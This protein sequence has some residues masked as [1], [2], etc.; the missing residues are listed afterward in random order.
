[1]STFIMYRKPISA[2]TPSLVYGYG[3]YAI[4]NICN[5]GQPLTTPDHSI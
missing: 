3:L 1:M 5:Y 4:E 2:F